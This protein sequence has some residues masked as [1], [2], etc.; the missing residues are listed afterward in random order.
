MANIQLMKI[1]PPPPSN[2]Y[3][4]LNYDTE[5]LWSITYP[6]EANII[7]INIIEVINMMDI[8]KNI[9]I[10]DMTAG[11]GGN[12]ISFCKY[13]DDVTGIE[14]NVDRFNILKNNIKQYQ[15]SNY[16]LIC[17][18]S[19]DYIEGDYNVYFIDPPWGGPNYKKQTNVELYMSDIKL[20]DF[21]EM[22]PEYRLIVLKLPFNY[23][24]NT[25]NKFNILLKLEMKNIN[26]IYLSR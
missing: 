19:K 7:S 23:N 6:N 10:V 2:N 15:S 20:I 12:T 4:L 8:K 3:S 9:K 26:I 13:F 5:G 14:K 17:G 24:I 21:I 11:L 25:L 18:D 22:I 16:T 1:F